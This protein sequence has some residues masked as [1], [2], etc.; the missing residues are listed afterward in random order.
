MNTL[1]SEKEEQDKVVIVEQKEVEKQLKL[2]GTLKP[3][4][5][6]TLFEINFK[7]GTIVEAEIEQ[8]DI[9]FQKA[10]NG[11]M[12]SNK[13]VIQKENC[14]YIPALNK[15]NASKKLLKLLEQQ[16]KRVQSQKQ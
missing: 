9:H 13:K 4:R 15:K 14:I 1:T 3:K 6:H 16:K 10:K 8:Q 12:S 11:R 5:G 7:E 2:I